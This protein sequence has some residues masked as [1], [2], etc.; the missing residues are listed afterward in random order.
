MQVRQRIGMNEISTMQ[1][2]QIQ[3]KYSE[4]EWK[5][6]VLDETNNNKIKIK[7]EMIDQSLVIENIDINY[8]ISIRNTHGN[9]VLCDYNWDEQ[10]TKEDRLIEF[11]ML[12][13]IDINKIFKK[14]ETLIIDYWLTITQINDKPFNHSRRFSMFLH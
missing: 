2:K 10:L 8:H 9:I 12:P 11:N 14:N 6:G 4:T 7:I 3:H 13:F 1:F 5:M